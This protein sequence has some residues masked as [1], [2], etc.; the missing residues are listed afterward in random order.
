MS[1][2]WLERLTGERLRRHLPGWRGCG[3]PYSA[4]FPISTRLGRVRGALPQGLR[5]GRRQRDRRRVRRR[6]GGG[7]RHGPAARAR[8]REPGRHPSSS[9]ATR[10]TRSST[11]A[12]PCSAGVSRPRHRRRLLQ[13][14]RGPCPL[15]RPL[16]LRHLLRRRPP[17]RPPAPAEGLCAARR[18]PAPARLR[19]DPGPDRPAELQDLDEDTEAPSP[20]SSGSSA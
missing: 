4:T 14:A 20:C 5:R 12:S 15:A 16:P 18:V 6:Q 10:S 17:G 7:C 9:V 1:E 11:S 19:A 3:S 13:R 8:A 2:I